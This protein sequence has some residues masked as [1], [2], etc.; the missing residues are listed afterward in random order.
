[1]NK[2]TARWLT[3]NLEMVILDIYCTLP[4]SRSV[5]F[6]EDILHIKK[7]YFGKNC[8]EKLSCLFAE[9]STNVLQSKIL[10]ARA[11][12]SPANVPHFAIA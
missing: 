7:F 10:F 9:I 8:S 6:T 4:V 11:L 1:M 5:V 3:F 2:V 12:A